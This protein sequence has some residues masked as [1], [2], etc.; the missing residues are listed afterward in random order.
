MSS[1]KEIQELLCP[2][3]HEFM[4]DPVVVTS[5]H[6]FERSA[7]Q[8]WINRTINEPSGPICPLTKKSIATTLIPNH[9]IRSLLAEKGH[10][11]VSLTGISQVR[12]GDFS[13]R[14]A[15]VLD[16]S[17][18]MD[19][20]VETQKNGEPTFSRLDLVKHSV[21][22]I[23]QMMT[24]SDEL[25]IITFSN[26]AHM[27]MDWT[28]MDALG[29]SRATRVISSLK[30][31]GCTNIPGGIELGIKQ[32][33]DHIILITDGANTTNP[34]SMSLDRYII[35]K[36]IDRNSYTKKI[37]SVGIG[38]CSDLDTFSVR[39]VSS[40]TNGFY[41][42]CPDASM[43]GTIFIHL[44]ANI[45]IG[46]EG[47]VPAEYDEFMS[48][49][50]SL[51]IDNNSKTVVQNNL[52]SVRNKKFNSQLLNDDLVSDDPNKGQVE[53][54]LLSWDTW[55]RHYLPAF[56]DSHTKKMTNNFK[57]AS[58]Q[59]YA[60]PR[61]RAFIESGEEIF[62]KIK[63][64]TPSCNGNE[65]RNVSRRHASYGISSRTPPN[66]PSS[67]GGL[68]PVPS[69]PLIIPGPDGTFTIDYNAPTRSNFARSTMTPSGGCFGPTTNLLVLMPGCFRN[70]YVATCIAKIKKGMIVKTDNGNAK[71]E[72]LIQ[73]PAQK[74][75]YRNYFWITEN[76][77]IASVSIPTAT[78][79]HTWYHAKNYPCVNMDIETNDVCYNLVLDH[80]H[81]VLI[82]QNSFSGSGKS[83]IKAVTF[84]HKKTGG[85]VEHDYL[86][87]D[88][89]INDLKKMSGWNTGFVKISAFKRT[90]GYINGIYDEHEFVIL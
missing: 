77:P 48:F 62:L 79:S 57:D 44:M 76:H 33:P 31:H 36:I 86:G 60:T 89:I 61:T 46:E 4:T 45:C 5:G 87:T 38:M 10:N 53:K 63:Q 13:V 47:Q 70:K 42:F 22:T 29:K 80:D 18:S 85:I 15:L 14:I 55:G 74:L 68:G 20:S 65:N 7:I 37:H 67:L 17:G 40:Y 83:S 41:C 3:T 84:G 72:C 9:V 35:T 21:E 11:I 16:I 75:I 82:G 1:D 81:V 90:N 50:L 32:S 64:P 88:K 19:T 66:S 78:A 28:E 51:N 39:K 30:S 6:T 34:P 2:I 58:I 27:V 8:E 59:D 73:C 52:E 56:I 12:S 49:L 71:V 26:D 23:S 69:G 43:V 54:A 24:A 25:S